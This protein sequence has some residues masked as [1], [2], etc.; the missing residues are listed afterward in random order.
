MSPTLFFFLGTLVA[1]VAIL[2]DQYT[3]LEKAKLK[4][5]GIGEDEKRLLMAMKQENDQLRERVQN[6]EY[7]VTNLDEHL[8]PPAQPES[9]DKAIQDQVKNIAKRLKN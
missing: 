5:G 2:S 1:I 9:D 4:S 8:L 6:L 3:K 7:I